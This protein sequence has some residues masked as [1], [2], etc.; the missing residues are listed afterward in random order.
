[1]T[2]KSDAPEVV[3][4]VDRL[5]AV[6]TGLVDGGTISTGA[7]DEALEV[8]TTYKVRKRGIEALRKNPALRD[9]IDGCGEEKPPE[10]RRLSVKRVAG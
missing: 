1:M 7:M 6:L 3:Y 10:G 5:A 4:D 8:V 9:L 2:G